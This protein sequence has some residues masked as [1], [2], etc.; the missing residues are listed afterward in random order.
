M[1]ADSTAALEVADYLNPVWKSLRQSLLDQHILVSES[2][3]LRFTQDAAFDSI[4][5]AAAI[6]VGATAMAVNCGGI[7]KVVR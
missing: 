3:Q 5:A 7:P 2:D 1:L 4:S 6:V